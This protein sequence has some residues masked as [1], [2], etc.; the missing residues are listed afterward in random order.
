M[1]YGRTLGVV[2]L[3]E[4][5]LTSFSW[6]LVFLIVIRV[7]FNPK[8]LLLPDCLNYSTNQLS[9]QGKRPTTASAIA[10]SNNG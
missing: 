5:R 3:P 8:Q 10:S 2:A 4:T 9:I 6:S 1:A 7:P